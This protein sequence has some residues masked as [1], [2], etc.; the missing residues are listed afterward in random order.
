MR[1]NLLL[2]LTSLCFIINA[3]DNKLLLCTE[4]FNDGTYSGAYEGWNIN[5][6][7]NY[8]YIFYESLSTI[9][10]TLF[11]RIDKS[12]NRKDTNYYEYDHYYLVPGESR[13]WAVNKYIFTKT[14]NYK[15][16]VF[17]RNNKQLAKP[18][19]TNIKIF[20]KDY[21]DMYFIDTWYYSQST[22]N[23]YEKTSGDTMYGKTDTFNY[24]LTGNKMIL[25]IAQ[26]NKLPF[27]T[28]H[29]LVSVYSADICHEHI[30]TYT[31][32]VDEKWYW[33]HIPLYIYR[34]GKFS[35]EVYNEDDV[36]I[37]SAKVEIK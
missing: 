37:N 23:F 33:T 26:E 24:Q 1:L 11:V 14:G 32:S 35:V 19:I 31:Y 15:I 18:Y 29:L 5:K 34:K 10:D 36:F 25:Y 16:T 13:K 3:Q 30:S 4:Y 22:I 2:F 7:G 27:K 9:N 17:D 28:S 20:D 21:N 8:M 12:F 6:D